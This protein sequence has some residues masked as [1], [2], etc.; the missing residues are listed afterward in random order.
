MPLHDMARLRIEHGERWLHMVE[1]QLCPPEIRMG[2]DAAIGNQQVATVITDGHVMCA[3]ALRI[4]LA[5]AAKPIGRIVKADHAAI[6]VE[7]IFAGIEQA[8]IRRE[9]SVTVIVTSLRRMNDNRCCLPGGVEDH[10]KR[11]GPAGKGNAAA[12][13][14]AVG[15]PMRPGG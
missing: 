3:D 4:K 8:A 15:Q 5:D 9:M 13:G 1:V 6:A 11:A 10:R 2:L 14:R 12:C 7:I